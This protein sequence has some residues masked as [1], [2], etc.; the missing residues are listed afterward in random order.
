MP[1]TTTT[2]I[3]RKNYL[4]RVFSGNNNGISQYVNG[5]E[6]YKD[7]NNITDAILSYNT[8]STGKGLI[9]NNSKTLRRANEELKSHVTRLKAELELER[10]K[11]KQIHRDKV[12]ELKRTKESYERANV[13]SIDL[14]TKKMK[15]INELEIKKIR[16]SLIRDKDLEIKQVIKYKDEEIKALQKSMQE[17]IDGLQHQQN[18]LQRNRGQ[19]KRRQNCDNDNENIVRMKNE[20]VVLQKSKEDLEGQVQSYATAINQKNDMIKK[21]KDGHERELQKILRE[22]R[23]ENSRSVSEMQSLRKSLQDKEVEMSKLENYA[24]KLSEEKDRLEK[25]SAI[26]TRS[27]QVS[28]MEQQVILQYLIFFT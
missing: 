4:S 15:N 26:L 22:A 8:P 13:V 14:I 20:I 7:N 18:R 6:V 28:N 10:I 3:Q 16:E 12:A 24:T 19:S 27:F 17:Q 25:E 11:S 5:G 1:A 21:L 2:S 9:R 23:R